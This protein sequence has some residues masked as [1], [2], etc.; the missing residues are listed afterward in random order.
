MFAKGAGVGG[1]AALA[2]GAV[3]FYV[4]R[5]SETVLPEW[6]YVHVVGAIIDTAFRQQGIANFTGTS[7]LRIIPKSFVAQYPIPAPSMKMQ[8]EWIAKIKQE[9]SIIEGNKR[10]IEIYTQKIEDRIGEVWGK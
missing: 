9:I 8:K 10:L 4:L 1:T 5:C 7:G 2:L 3:E 6:I